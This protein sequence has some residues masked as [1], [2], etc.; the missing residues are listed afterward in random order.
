LNNK[1]L[2]EEGMTRQYHSF[3]VQCWQLDGDER[4]I[5]IEHLQSGESAQVAS[6]ARL[7]RWIEARWSQTEAAPPKVSK[8]Q[9][10]E[11]VPSKRLPRG[12]KTQAATKK[13]QKEGTEQ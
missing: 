13:Q 8:R 7:A 10:S 3:M 11:G 12:N 2:L 4:R 6:L 5:K 9:H 1:A